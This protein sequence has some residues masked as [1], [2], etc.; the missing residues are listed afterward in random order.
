MTADEAVI[1][2]LHPHRVSCQGMVGDAGSDRLIGGPAFRATRQII[3]CHWAEAFVATI[4]T[5]ARIKC[6][7]RWDCHIPCPTGVAAVPSSA[8]P[9]RPQALFLSECCPR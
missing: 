1:A 5:S 6:G 2:D 4:A 7:V 8:R 3:I 9:E